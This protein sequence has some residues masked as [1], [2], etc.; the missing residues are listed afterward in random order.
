MPVTRALLYLYRA[1]KRRLIPFFS[2]LLLLLLLSLYQK[3]LPPPP[4]LP[5]FVFLLY[6]CFFFHSILDSFLSSLSRPLSS[7]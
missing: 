2:P 4:S 6:A 5:A 1:V 3:T 7:Y